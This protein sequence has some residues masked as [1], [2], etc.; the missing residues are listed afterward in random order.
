MLAVA[1]ALLVPSAGLAQQQPSAGLAVTTP[2]E[3]L[4]AVD[5]VLD[6][7]AKGAADL[8]RR[9]G[10]NVAGN[11]TGNDTGTGAASGTAGAKDSYTAALTR[12]E[13]IAI[14]E[15]DP[16]LQEF[17]DDNPIHRT[18][19]E[20]QSK[21]RKW[22]VSFVGGPKDAEVVEAEVY[23]GDEEGNIAEV[24]TGPQVAWMMA[25]GYE[26]AFGRAVNRWRIWIPL[27]LVF[28]L[29]LLPIT[30]PRSLLS[31]RTLDL[32]VLL[33]F[34]VSWAWFNQG[35]IST[36]VPLQYP[37]LIYLLARMAWI[38]VH[39]AR[40]R[41]GGGAG[42]PNPGDSHRS[43]TV[44]PSAPG[45][46]PA[47][48][49]MPGAAPAASPAPGATSSPPPPPPPA[50]GPRTPG[51]PGWMPTWL[52][53]TVL[54]ILIALRWG[55]NGLNSNVIDVGY[56]GVIGSDL[57][58]DGQTPYGNFP[59]DCGQ[60]DTYGPLNYIS[61]IPFEA[62]MPFTGKWD[63][64]PAAHGA[65][66][67]FDGLTLLA[68]LVLGWRL[69]GRKMG[70]TFAIAWAAFPFTA[71]TLSSNS[72]DAL[73]S[74]CVAWGLVLAA[75]PL[76]RGVMIGLGVA[77][78]IV[79]AILVP[80]WARH[81]FPRAD[82]GAGPRRLVAYIGGLVIAALLTGWVLLL[83]GTAGI[84]NFWSRTIGYQADRE[85]PFSIWG[86]FEWLRPVHIAVGALVILAALL[87]MRWP[88]R[89]DLVQWAA[90]S[91]ALMIGFELVLTHWFYLY[92]PWFLPMVILVVVPLWPD[93]E[94][95]PA[96][97]PGRWL[98][99]LRRMTRAKKADD[100][101]APGA[102][103]GPAAGGGTA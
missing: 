88:R 10:A 69:A 62:V 20:F 28:L 103:P 92:I 80:L 68:L 1:L 41:R 93:P 100:A 18:A 61:Y 3:A 37:P 77:A 29:V 8:Q 40:L 13:A 4:A 42:D 22:K 19:A 30:R 9:A 25:R 38:T 97:P 44:T 89:L 65:A 96:I 66:A 36:S 64:L 84:R 85:S 54:V 58:L 60:C 57:I 11:G 79:P 73:I 12:D 27:C 53:V 82:R 102:Q 33:S 2:S 91:A 15:A 6:G 86:Q 16:G 5:G 32:L 51:L 43:V 99:R 7:L 98:S 23:V 78:K 59:D 95:E 52:L 76:G 45:A 14:A 26:G 31:W 67:L 83:D 94:P 87:V 24:R 72:N 21:D 70:L 55:L 34:T 90:I 47:A 48:S 71:F 46:T 74:A 56:A 63:D 81:P 17:L 35:D 49:S 39:R 101:Q 50:R 75:R